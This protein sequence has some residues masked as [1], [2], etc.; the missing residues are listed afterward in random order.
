MGFDDRARRRAVLS[1]CT[2]A[3]TGAA[4]SCALI[5]NIGDLPYPA[6]GAVADQNATGPDTSTDSPTGP[7][8]TSDTSV[9]PDSSSDVSTHGS[10][11]GGLTSCGSQCLDTTKNPQSCGRCGHDC[12]G[13]ACLGGACQPV[14]LAAVNGTPED[15]VVRPSGVYWVN[16][17]EPGSLLTVP[18]DGGAVSALAPPYDGGGAFV[19]IDDTSVYWSFDT[20]VMKVSLDGGGLT[21]LASRSLPTKGV[22]VNAD[23]VT[24][25]DFG[26]AGGVLQVPLNGGGATPLAPNQNNVGALT[27][28]STTAYWAAS[29]SGTIVK[30][31]L[32]GGAPVVVSNVAGPYGIAVDSTNIYWTASN[33]VAGGGALYVSPLSGGAGGT[34]IV[35]NLDYPGGL[36]VDGTGA[37]WVNTGDGTVEMVPLDGG[38]PLTLVTSEAA[39]QFVAIDATSVYW[40]NSVYQG[41]VRKVAKP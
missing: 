33:D 2:L 40:T 18:L 28:D 27:L 38:A 3:A 1:L 14:T 39:P 24:W 30:A 20:W 26:T 23:Y 4:A 7:D 15:L 19:A 16:D 21:Q 5:A 25:A 17:G 32:D 11:D 13:G 41:K 37:Y 35:Q 10:C 22:A 8:A 6:D 34:P 29:G 31:T 9:G 36:A 12:Q